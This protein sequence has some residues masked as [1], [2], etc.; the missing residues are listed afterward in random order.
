MQCPL[1]DERRLRKRT[2]PIEGRAGASLLLK[3]M[4][5]RCSRWEKTG[6]TNIV[7]GDARCFIQ[8]RKRAAGSAH[9]GR[10]WCC[11][12]APELLTHRHG[13]N[14]QLKRECGY[15]RVVSRSRLCRDNSSPAK[16]LALAEPLSPASADVYPQIRGD[17]LHRALNPR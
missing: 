2:V 14:K 5:R 15:G 6:T 17:V 16:F 3:N 4:C 11:R 7:G 8:K 10:S 9:Y 12:S 1:N 13:P